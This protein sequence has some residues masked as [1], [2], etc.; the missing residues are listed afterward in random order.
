VAAGKKIIVALYLS[1]VTFSAA[2]QAPPAKVYG[3]FQ[4]AALYADN[5]KQRPEMA[6]WSDKELF[7]GLTGA[8]LQTK[9]FGRGLPPCTVHRGEKII[10][11]ADGFGQ[12]WVSL[13]PGTHILTGRCRGYRNVNVEVNVKA[14][15]KY[16]INF[17]M[18]KENTEKKRAKHNRRAGRGK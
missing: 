16:Y 2:A 3:E 15:G 12:F 17:I 18:P 6:G 8:T 5:L 14:G 13:A 7:D 1:A 9:T 10:A 4:D 11:Y